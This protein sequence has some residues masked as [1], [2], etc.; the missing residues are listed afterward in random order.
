ML[1]EGLGGE[2][3]GDDGADEDDVVEADEGGLHLRLPQRQARPHL[4]PHHP[5]SQPL[6]PTPTRVSKWEG[7]LIE[8]DEGEVGRLPRQVEL[9]R[10]AEHEPDGAPVAPKQG[11]AQPSLSL[12][13]PGRGVKMRGGPFG[14]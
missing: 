12:G 6:P 7:P 11:L 1:G 14:A 3:E 4:L 5:A 2:L 13:G 9:H 10:R 8:E